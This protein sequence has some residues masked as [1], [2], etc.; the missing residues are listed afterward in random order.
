[1]LHPWT[2]ILPFFIIEWLARK[3]CGR[4]PVGKSN[5]IEVYDKV[6]I[7]EDKEHFTSLH[8]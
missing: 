8:C 7:R 5:Y 6:L 4:I 2:K 3:W 1:M